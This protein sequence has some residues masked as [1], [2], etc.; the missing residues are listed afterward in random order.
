MWINMELA[1]IVKVTNV[2]FSLYNLDFYRLPYGSNSIRTEL[3]KKTSSYAKFR[4]EP[5]SSLGYKF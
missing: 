5:F 3:K 4:Q 1:E 2:L